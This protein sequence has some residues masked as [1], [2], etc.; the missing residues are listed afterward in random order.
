VDNTAGFSDCP[1]LL[2]STGNLQTRFAP[3]QKIYTGAKWLND[4]KLWYYCEGLIV[5]ETGK[6]LWEPG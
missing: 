3:A 4:H 1:A 6:R 5:G 2:K